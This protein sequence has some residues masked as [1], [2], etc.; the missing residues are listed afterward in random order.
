MTA[1]PSLDAVP[2][3]FDNHGEMVEIALLLPAKRA[4]ALVALSRRRH[5]TVGQILRALI[6]RALCAEE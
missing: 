5:E 4:E 6:D 2:I 3:T 1:Y